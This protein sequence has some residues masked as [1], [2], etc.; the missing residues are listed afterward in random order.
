M[1]EWCQLLMAAERDLKMSRDRRAM[2][3]HY[4]HGWLSMSLLPAHVQSLHSRPPFLLPLLSPMTKTRRGDREPEIRLPDGVPVRPQGLSVR[5]LHENEAP[6]RLCIRRNGAV[7]MATKMGSPPRPL[8]LAMSWK[9][10]L[11]RT[12]RHTEPID[13]HDVFC[14]DEM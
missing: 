6:R 14:M 2:K 8:V 1:I 4:L 13:R 3:L 7:S 12:Q 11:P 9:M 10:I 5:P